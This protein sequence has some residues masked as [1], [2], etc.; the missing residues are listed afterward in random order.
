LGRNDY[1]GR[2]AGSLENHYAF[3]PREELQGAV[4]SILMFLADRHWFSR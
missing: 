2:T 4:F 1:F 3:L